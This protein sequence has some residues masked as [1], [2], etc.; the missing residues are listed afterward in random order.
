MGIQWEPHNCTPYGIPKVDRQLLM[1]PGR[2]RVPQVEVARVG[3]RHGLAQ[4]LPQVKVSS[5]LST[6]EYVSIRK[7]QY[8]LLSHVWID[9]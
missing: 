4:H 5:T 2:G 8:R 7:D 6:Y 3:W 9:N 1:G